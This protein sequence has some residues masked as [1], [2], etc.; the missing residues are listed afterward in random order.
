MSASASCPKTLT[1]TDKVVFFET[2]GNRSR[3]YA[4]L[5]LYQ[6]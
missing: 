6:Q 4:F 3:F 2:C 1:K 5:Y